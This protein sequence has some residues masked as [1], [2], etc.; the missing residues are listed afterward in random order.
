MLRLLRVPRHVNLRL[1]AIRR[2][3]RREDLSFINA[4]ILARETHLAITSPERVTHRQNLSRARVSLI[5]VQK[6]SVPALLHCRAARHDIQTHAT[7]NQTRQ[8][9]DLLHEG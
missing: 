1:A 5:V 8:R 2:E 6:I 7:T 4:T 9:V 3:K